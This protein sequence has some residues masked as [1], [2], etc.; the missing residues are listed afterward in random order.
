M[1][2]VNFKTSTFI[3]SLYNVGISGVLK[4]EVT[5]VAQDQ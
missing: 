1:W 4:S 3:I 5:S 2:Y